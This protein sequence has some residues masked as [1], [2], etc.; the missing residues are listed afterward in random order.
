MVVVVV[1]KR[2]LVWGVGCEQPP[3][4]GTWGPTETRA[5]EKPTLKAD[6]ET[7][8]ATEQEENENEDSNQDPKNQTQTNIEPG[9]EMKMTVTMTMTMTMTMKIHTCSKSFRI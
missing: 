8:R 9:T 6:C 2:M 5:G 7:N 1:G 4:S 3:A